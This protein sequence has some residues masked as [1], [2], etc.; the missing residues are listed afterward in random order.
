VAGLV[1]VADSMEFLV[2]RVLPVVVAVGINHRLAVPVVGR[3]ALVSI[4]QSQIL[5]EKFISD[6]VGLLHLGTQ[7]RRV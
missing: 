6:L 3:V 1:L 7:A 4:D 2:D 5:L